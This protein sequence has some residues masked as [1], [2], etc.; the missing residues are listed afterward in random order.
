MLNPEDYLFF[1]LD[2]KIKN[3]NLWSYSFIPV[4]KL[5]D[6]KY[7][8]CV[9]KINPDILKDNIINVNQDIKFKFS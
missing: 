7:K 4:N 8:C 9:S 5:V 3:C 1:H 2:L 6:K